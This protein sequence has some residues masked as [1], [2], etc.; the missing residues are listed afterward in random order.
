[1]FVIENRITETE[2]PNNA[3]KKTEQVVNQATQ[4]NKSF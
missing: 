1:M 4:Q 3:L 2:S